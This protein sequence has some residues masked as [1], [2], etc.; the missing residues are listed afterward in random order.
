MT[1][2]STD[3]AQ[4]RAKD[5]AKPFM[6]AVLMLGTMEGPNG[7]DIAA[8]WRQPLEA[9]LS[10]AGEVIAVDVRAPHLLY[11]QVL[12][13]DFSAIHSAV[14]RAAA[15]F[16]SNITFFDMHAV[17]SQVEGGTHRFNV[18]AVKQP[19]VDGMVYGGP[20][21][22][23]M[24]ALEAERDAAKQAAAAATADAIDT[25]KKAAAKAGAG[26]PEMVAAKVQAEAVAKAAADAEA[27]VMADADSKAEHLIACLPST[28]PLVPV[29]LED[30]IALLEGGDVS[31]L[32]QRLLAGVDLRALAATL[33]GVNTSIKALA[34]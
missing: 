2:T 14:R 17:V 18:Y 24:K 1:Q 9:P 6:A 33:H 28:V 26:D 15:V 11:E 34:A 7:K 21:K 22:P 25:A 10:A 19:M 30:F 23:Q 3:I 27:K 31:P 16:T 4:P 5:S 20:I 12:G 8:V 29:P 32:E 13:D